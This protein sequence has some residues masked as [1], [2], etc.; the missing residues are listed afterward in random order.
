MVSINFR[1]NYEVRKEE[2]NN[3][4]R[5]S[6]YEY[7]GVNNKAIKV[8]DEYLNTEVF[9]RN[10]KNGR[11]HLFTAHGKKYSGTEEYPQLKVFL[12]Y[13]IKKIIKGKERHI[14]DSNERRNMKEILKI[15][16]QLVST[17]IGFLEEKDKKCA[18]TTI[19]LKDKDTLLKI[20]NKEFKSYDK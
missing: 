5:N 10:T 14:N 18:H 3:S 9:I 6:G 8:K 1:I 20:L 19:E 16:N 11:Y 13:D 17:N 7:I 12:H 15:E 2:I 4:L